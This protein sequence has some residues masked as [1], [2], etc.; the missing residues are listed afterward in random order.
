MIVLQ[1]VL[2]TKINGFAKVKLLCHFYFKK[3]NVNIIAPSLKFKILFF[4]FF[5]FERMRV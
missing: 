4:L 2:F 1:F 5:R 3:L